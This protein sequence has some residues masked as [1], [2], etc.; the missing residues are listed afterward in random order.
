M[1]LSR[2]VARDY[3]DNNSFQPAAVCANATVY[4]NL[5]HDS[6]STHACQCQCTGTFTMERIANKATEVQDCSDQSHQLAP[7]LAHPAYICKCRELLFA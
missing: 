2:T 5:N 1:I 6:Q 7:R 3:D 4:R